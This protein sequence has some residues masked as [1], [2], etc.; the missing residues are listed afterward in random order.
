MM[1]DGCLYNSGT[2]VATFGTSSVSSIGHLG[3]FDRS[4]E[5]TGKRRHEPG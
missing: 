5:F 1:G 2:T 3:S 4:I